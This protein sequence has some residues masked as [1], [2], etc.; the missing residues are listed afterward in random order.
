MI[1]PALYRDFPTPE[2]LAATTPEVVY[3]YIRSAAEHIRSGKGPVFVEAQTYRY[4]GH[5]KSDRNLYR[6]KE[7][8]DHWKSVEDPIIRFEKLLQAANLIDANGIGK[9]KEGMTKVIEESVTY[10]ENSPEPD[11]RDVT[12]WVYA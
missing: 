3:E 11:V 9:I 1:T 6:T 4:F 12:E 2:A 8:I 7:E 10:A 5:S